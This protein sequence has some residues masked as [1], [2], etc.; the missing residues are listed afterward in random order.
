MGKEASE[1]VILFKYWE[2]GIEMGS[3]LNL[4]AAPKETAC[5]CEQL[6]FAEEI[7][8]DLYSYLV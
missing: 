6:L 1:G 4:E 7:S 2:V 8:N 5:T 3:N